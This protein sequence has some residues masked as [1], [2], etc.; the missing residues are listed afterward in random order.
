MILK[1]GPCRTCGVMLSTKG[2]RLIRFKAI[3]GDVAPDMLDTLL[4]RCTTCL[5]LELRRRGGQ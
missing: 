3:D 1:S 2:L 4:P 5:K